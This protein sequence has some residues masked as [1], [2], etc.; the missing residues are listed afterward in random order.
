MKTQRHNSLN[1]FF[2]TAAVS[3]LVFCQPN[4]LEAAKYSKLW[5]KDGEKWSPTSRL[6]DFSYAGYH[7][8]EK[9]LPNYKGVV[10]VKKTGA[11]GDGSSDDTQAFLDAIKKAKG[12]AIL[13]P[14]G[15]Y[16]I[17]K[18]LNL[19]K[20]N[21]A[22]RGEGPDKTI[23]F[24]PKPLTEIAPL[25]GAKTTG[26]RKTSR[27]SWSFGV[28]S[29][30]GYTSSKKI[31]DITEPAKRGD[32]ELKISIG[33]QV[34]KKKKDKRSKKM[35]GAL[36][37]GQWIEVYAVEDGQKSLTKYLYSEETGN[38]SNMKPAYVSMVA[39]VKSVQGGLL[40]LDR[41]LRF[42]L[43]K[44]W[45]PQIR[46]YQ[47]RIE[48]S[49][50]EDLT[51]EFPETKYGGHFSEK[52]YNGIGMYGVSNCWLKNITIK[53]ADS[54]IFLKSRFVTMKNIVID[55]KRDAKKATTGH[56]GILI[57]GHDNL[58]DGFEINTMFIHDFTVTNNCSHNV[59][60]NGKGLDIS[61]D[62]HCKA[63]YENLFTNIDMGTGKRIWHCGGGGGLGKHCG[64]RGTFW[65]LRGQKP[66]KYPH[67]NFGPS[68][69]NLVAITTKDK[70]QCDPNG[71]WFE[72]ISPKSISPENLYEAQLAKR[73]GKPGG[74]SDAKSKS[75]KKKKGGYIRLF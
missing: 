70:S 22:L 53:N 5:G 52:G 44:S 10:N 49:G 58:L 74:G 43:Q 57:T 68:S 23:L 6:P 17:T 45:S 61:L 34:S 59:I 19:N 11:K 63:P 54:G 42:D 28:L 69:I 41:P 32:L 16:K 24:F 1:W 46:Q 14:E 12:G 13:V 48:E 71:K 26:G 30:R 31:S 40:K 37:P 4:K 21:I 36:T 73:L 65:N 72:A 18:V 33:K 20:S 47:P 64:A 66:F 29:M 62:H 75:K 67:K 9:P 27:Y 3:F 56:H 38:I 25:K 55:S 51:I 8:G 60:A 50:I 2:L 15:R 35:G 7:S 39:K